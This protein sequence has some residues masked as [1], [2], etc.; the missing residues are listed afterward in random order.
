MNV[1][2]TDVRTDETPG[3]ACVDGNGRFVQGAQNA[4][5]VEC[6]FFKGGVPVDGADSYWLMRMADR[7]AY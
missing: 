3:L 7:V 5:T 2:G 6:Y 1:L 4:E